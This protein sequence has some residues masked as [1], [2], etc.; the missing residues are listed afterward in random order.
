MFLMA[1]CMVMPPPSAS[2]QTLSLFRR[3]QVSRVAVVGSVLLD[4]LAVP[5]GEAPTF[6]CSCVC[7]LR[8]WCDLWCDDTGSGQCLFSNMV[9]LP[10]YQESDT[11]N[12]LNCYTRRQREFAA[13]ALIRATPDSGGKPATNLV[14][15]FYDGKTLGLCYHTVLSVDNPWIL[16]DFR[17]PVTFRH[18]KFVLQPAG[19]ISTVQHARNMAARTGMEDVATAGDFTAYDFFGDFAGPA[20]DYGQEVI[21]ESPEAVTARFLSLQKMELGTYFQICHIEVY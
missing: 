12:A 2:T 4:A 20:T 1:V 10:A 18:V 19:A 15:G 16:L 8:A 6:R 11:S 14:D 5:P 13:G 3:V 7:N 17:V 21:I 9:V